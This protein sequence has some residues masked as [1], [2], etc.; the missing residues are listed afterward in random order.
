MHRIIKSHLESF[1][2]S[3]RIEHHDESVQFEMFVN[4]SV[5]SPK[6]IGSIEIESI[7]SSDADDGIDGIAI[8]ISE[9]LILSDEDGKSI[10]DSERSNHD[11]EIICIQSKRS[12]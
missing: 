9:E 5:L 8:L 7:T 6:M 2:K 1:S 4:Y 3:N 12:E 11:V 10:F